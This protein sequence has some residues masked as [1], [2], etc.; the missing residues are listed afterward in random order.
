M[1]G[2]SEN[3]RV[4]SEDFPIS[5]VEMRY[6]RNAKITSMYSGFIARYNY[7]RRELSQYK[8]IDAFF[9]SWRVWDRNGEREGERRS[10]T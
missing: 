8:Y 6:F 10:I 5:G 4:T 7:V 2:I 1:T 3:V 9:L